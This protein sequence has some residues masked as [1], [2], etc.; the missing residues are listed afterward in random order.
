MDLVEDGQ[1]RSDIEVTFTY[2]GATLKA[3]TNADGRARVNFGK[4]G[5]D[6]LEARAD[7]WPTQ[8]IAVRMPTDCP[9]VGGTSSGQVLG[10]ST[11]SNN[12]QRSSGQVL[13][14]TTLA[15]T[16]QASE[17]LAQ[18]AIGLGLGLIIASRF[19][20]AQNRFS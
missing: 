2:H 16:G 18:A 13:G 12:N 20:L 3:K 1:G 10:T 17:S 19:I 6:T 9:A 15:S 7:G 5:D 8:S 4:N 14:A 11:Q